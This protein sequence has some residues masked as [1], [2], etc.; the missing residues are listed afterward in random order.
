M[1][2]STAERL[3]GGIWGLLVGDA[4]GV[5]YEFQQ[6]S[7]LPSVERIDLVPPTGF[8][9]SHGGIAPGTW[10]DD[11]AQALCLLDSLLHCGR[12]DEEDLARRLANWLEHGYL[13]VDGLVFDVGITTRQAL[14]RF[15]S[16]T[17]AARSGLD[18]E[19]DNGNG[20]LMRVLPLAAWHRGTDRDLALDAHRQSLPTHAHP[21]SQ[22]CCA[23]YCLW[24]RRILQEHPEPW[25][26]AVRTL[27]GLYADLPALAH[28][29]HTVILPAGEKP[30]R[31]SG[32]VVDTLHSARWAVS[33]RGYEA[34]VRAAV[35]LGNDTDTTACVAGGI[36]GLRDGIRALPDRWLTAMRD[37]DLVRPLVQALLE[38]PP[39]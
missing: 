11:G 23:L 20:A 4:V 39:G 31:G 36:A 21:R 1:T 14:A 28:E 13:A 7:A 12:L 8:R 2:L 18:G 32:Y 22:A 38:L 29:L 30:P 37:P 27:T 19:R 25:E 24:A 35:S 5:P 3:E 34:A 6:A 10:S 26:D 15:R 17:P 33:G 16:G 9:R